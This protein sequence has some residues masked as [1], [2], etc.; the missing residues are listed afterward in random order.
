[1]TP[2]PV[3]RLNCSMPE[4][5]LVTLSCPPNPRVIGTEKALALDLEG[6]TCAEAQTHTSPLARSQDVG[7]CA[8]A[9]GAGQAVSAVS[10]L[11]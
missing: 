9:D 7:F 3:S 5:F 1:M 4:D 2:D 8:G 6:T 11:V 10:G